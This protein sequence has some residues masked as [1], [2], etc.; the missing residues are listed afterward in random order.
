MASLCV[1]TPSH[2]ATPVYGK[3]D[4]LSE[5]V[6]HI[7]TNTCLHGELVKG[8]DWLLML[9]SSDYYIKIQK[10]IACPNDRVEIE[11]KHNQDTKG[12][13]SQPQH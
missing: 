2:E 1:C 5:I 6:G 7:S 10:L 9:G 4:S 8:K 3:S 11:R 12:N 13:R